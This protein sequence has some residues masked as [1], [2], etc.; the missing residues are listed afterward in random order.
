M[1]N[2]INYDDYRLFSSS[3]QGTLFYWLD[4][5]T[6]V[7]TAFAI[8]AND[9]NL[10]HIIHGAMVRNWGPVT[11]NLVKLNGIIFGAMLGSIG[12]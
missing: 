6:P 9:L 8:Q 12:V 4:P 5:W 3:S 10:Q 2:Y 1:I 11:A 7:D